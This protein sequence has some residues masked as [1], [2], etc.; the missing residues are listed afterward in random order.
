MFVFER[1]A[2]EALAYTRAEE[3]RV[4]C[5]EDQFMPFGQ[6]LTAETTAYRA[7]T[8]AN[9]CSAC[10]RPPVFFPVPYCQNPK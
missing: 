1:V 8:A 5:A 7:R 2:D 9:S 4:R 10:E 6:G 3:K